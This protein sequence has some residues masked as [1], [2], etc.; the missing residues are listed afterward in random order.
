MTPTDIVLETEWPHRPPVSEMCEALVGKV[1]II[2]WR[3]PR[4]DTVSAP[5]IESHVKDFRDYY[6]DKV[7]INMIVAYPTKW[8]SKLSALSDLPKDT[9]GVQQVVINV[10]DDNFSKI[11][12]KDHVEFINRLRTWESAQ[13]A[14]MTVMARIVLKAEEKEVDWLI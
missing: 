14:I 1:A 2:D 5:K 3:D 8:S 13:P 12:P 9:S 6:Q 11:F 10:G 7:Y 4:F